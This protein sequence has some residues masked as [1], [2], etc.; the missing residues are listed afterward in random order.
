MSIFFRYLF[1][2]TIA[3]C[4]VA[5]LVFVGVLVL[6]NAIRDIFEWIA[7]G[8][9]SVFES[10]KIL[11]IVLP[12]V[13]SY[14]LPLGMFTGILLTISRLSVSNELLI[15]KGVGMSVPRISIPIFLIAVCATMLSGVINLYYAP[16]SL[17]KYRSSFREIL[18]KNPIRFIQPNEFIDWF[19]GYIIHV[20]SIR[21]GELLKLKIWQLENNEVVCYLSAEHGKMKYDY[22]DGTIMLELFDGN[23]EHFEGGKKG[24]SGHGSDSLFFQELSLSLPITGIFKQSGTREKKLRHMNFTELLHA[25]NNW[26]SDPSADISP[27]IIKKDRVLVDTQISSNI[28]MTLGVLAMSFIAIPL[29]IRKNRA[30]TTSNVLLAFVIAF[31]YYFSV[32][33]LS[34]FGGCTWLHPELLVWL[35]NAILFGLGGYL[36]QRVGR[37]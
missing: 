36:M 10:I 2:N 25:R 30:D 37:H 4:T 17:T 31:V 29:G 11:S 27:E 21:D 7:C 15:M 5:V 24:G 14:A 33:V 26:H 18:R 1:K 32:V 34:W 13:V 3:S 12:S 20:D 22:G 28:A 9:L 19:P 8:R 23:A 16:D 35:P 6:G